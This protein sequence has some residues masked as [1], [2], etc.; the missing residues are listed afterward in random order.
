MNLRTPFTSGS[1]RASGD[2]ACS[3]LLVLALTLMPATATW[4]QREGVDVGNNSRLAGLVPA[5]EVESAANQQYHE[6]LQQAAAKQ[7]LAAPGDPQLVRL[8]EIARRLIPQSAAWNPRA[9]G[10]HW[11]VNLI[12]SK[13]INAFCMPGGKIAVFTGILEKLQLTD[14]ELAMVLGHEMAHALREHARERIAKN[15][16]T[17]IGANILTQVLGLGQIGQ[18]ITGYGAQLLTLRFSRG[19]ESEA[20]LVGM[21]IAARA[22]YD[23]RAAISLWQKMGE[24]SK[25]EPPQWLSSHPAGATRIA[26]LQRNLPRVM[27]LYERTAAKR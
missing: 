21:E 27:P 18:T 13:P 20:D 9:T 3:L 4:A 2:A 5:A 19:D 23:P 24:A 11:E 16:A 8:R 17:S 10:W 26:D 14:D 15:A 12:R 7:A 22:G 6:L 1:I 25:G